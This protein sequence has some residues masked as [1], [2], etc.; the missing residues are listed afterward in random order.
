MA[1]QQA[2]QI[3]NTQNQLGL[4]EDNNKNDILGSNSG[5]ELLEYID[6]DLRNKFFANQNVKMVECR[7]INGGYYMVYQKSDGSN[8]AYEVA[9]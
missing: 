9:V 3:K 1:I 4:R 6:K 7:T 8:V 2:Q 5:K